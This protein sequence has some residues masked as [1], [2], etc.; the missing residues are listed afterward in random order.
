MIKVFDNQYSTLD[1]D[2]PSI[3]K[4]VEVI[5]RVQAEC[6]CDKEDKKYSCISKATLCMEVCC[7]LKG[8]VGTFQTTERLKNF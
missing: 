2:E 6:T 8:L 3:L 5:N 1:I 7:I 4:V